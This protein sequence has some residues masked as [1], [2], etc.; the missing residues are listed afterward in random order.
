M[1]GILGRVNRAT[2]NITLFEVG[3]RRLNKKYWPYRIAIESNNSDRFSEI[4]DWLRGK[5]PGKDEWNL[6]Y[7]VNDTKCD[8]YFR[9][10]SAAVMFA[11]RWV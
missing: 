9:D 7:S 4:C 1:G 5:L 2:S 8:F 11:M 6:V 10:E 3:M